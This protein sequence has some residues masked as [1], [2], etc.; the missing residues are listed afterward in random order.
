MLKGKSAV[1]TG[2]DRGIGRSIAGKFCENGANVLI[3]YRSN[4][5]QAEKAAE[6]LGKFG[7]KVLLFKGD[8]AD[9]QTAEGAVA[10]AKEE[11]GSV[12]ILVNNA[13]ITDDKLLARMQRV[14]PVRDVNDYRLAPLR[15]RDIVIP[16][17]I[18]QGGMGVGVSLGGL[19]G[20][21]AREGGVGCVAATECGYGDPE[22]EKRPVRSNLRALKTEVQKA[23]RISAVG[24]PGPVA[25]N[26]PYTTEH[27]SEY[28]EAA[29]EAGARII[30]SG[31]GIPTSLPGI[32]G[33]RSVALIPII[34]SPRGARVIIKNWQ[35]KHGRTPDAFIFEGPYA[36]GTLGYKTEK[37]DRA[38][39]EFYA[40]LVEVREEISQLG[41][42]PLIVG[43]GIYTREDAKKAFAYGADGIQ[44]GTRFVTTEECDA[45]EAFKQAYIDAE[46]PDIALVAVPGEKPWNT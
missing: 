32:V 19:A 25:V 33:D 6:E 16:V 18:F 40:D 15:I 24:T 27:Y 34:S 14:P 35:K 31:A 45:D 26:I 10:K 12:D 7:T 9:P 42:C 5:E 41:N 46:E 28:V 8:V 38:R 4:D 37:I 2:G 1:I 22:Y 43:G 13:G 3:V 44:I 11:F 23:L 20:E 29:I 17:P 30:I 21:V 36:G 39:E